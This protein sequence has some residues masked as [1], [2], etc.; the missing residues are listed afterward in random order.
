MEKQ[1]LSRNRED[2]SP[3]VQAIIHASA[4]VFYGGDLDAAWEAFFVSAEQPFEIA[5]NDPYQNHSVL[6]LR[7]PA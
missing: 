5:T 6:H 4:P 3:K 1:T 7:L 2:Y